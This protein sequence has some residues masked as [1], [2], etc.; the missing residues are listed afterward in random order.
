MHLVYGTY[1]HADNECSITIDRQSVMNEAGQQYALDHTWTINGIIQADDTDEV[2][3]AYSLMEIAYSR[4]YQNL[5][6]YTDDGTR[7]HSLLNAGSLTGVRIMKPPYY[8]K[9]EGAELSTFRSYSIVATCR[10][11]AIGATNP[12]KSFTEILQMSGGGP[13]RAVVECVNL[14][15]QEQVLQLYTAYRA[16][17]AGQA[18]GM[19]AYPPVQP[20]IFP[21]K[22]VVLDV[23]P[24]GAQ[25][26][27]PKLL[28][29]IYVDWPVSWHY[30]YISATPLV[31][32][33]HRWP[34]G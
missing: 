2:I 3:L 23:V 4:W 31:G 30:E 29:G 13:R 27:S 21:G 6:F 26:G 20:P 8:P 15:P 33:P 22:Q 25:Y 19:Y 17:Q 7:A 11:P 1:E 28:N 10:Y 18:V 12:L 5:V 34:A 9:G 16:V 14:P 32:L 24:G